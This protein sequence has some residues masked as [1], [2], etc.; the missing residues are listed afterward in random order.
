L[1][2]RVQDSGFRV[3]QTLLEEFRGM[4]QRSD[5]TGLGCRVSGDTVP[6]RMAIIVLDMMTPAILHGTLPPEDTGS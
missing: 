6:C 4:T 1:G 5:A 3:H 2:F